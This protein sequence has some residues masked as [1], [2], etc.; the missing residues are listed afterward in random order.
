MTIFSPRASAMAHHEGDEVGIDWADACND[1]IARV[2]DLF[3]ETFVGV[4]Q[5]PQHAGEP[6]DAA[7]RPSC[8]AASTSWA[9]SAATSTP[10]RAAGAGAR[11][12]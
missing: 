7:H 10:T 8:A 2:V 9:S 4:C 6:L 1:L 12:R 11:R 5:L 3:P